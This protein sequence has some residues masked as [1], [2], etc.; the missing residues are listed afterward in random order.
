MRSS[1][2]RPWLSNRHSSTLSALAENSAKLVPR[3]SQLA[4]RREKVPAVR[5]IKLAFRGQ[6][7]RGQRRDGEIELA[8]WPIR[9]LNAADIAD[10]GAA[11]MGG[12][13]IEY[14]T[15][16]AAKRHPDA[17]I[18]INIRREIDDDDAA[19]AG[20]AALAHPCEHVVIGV[21]GN[22]PLKTIR[23]AVELMQC[24]RVAIEAVEVS[25]QSLNAGMPAL[26]EQVPVQRMV[27]SPFAF[28]REFAAHEQE[29]LAGMAEHEAVIGAQVCKALPVVAGHAP[30]DRACAVHHLVMRQRQDEVFR[31]GIVQAEQ[32]VAVV[33]F[34]VDGILA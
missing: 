23:L 16:F 19:R 11:I 15:P 22:D 21:F 4:P 28:L 20:V 29:L 3:P 32:D 17:V 7:Y 6:E 31:E 8:R 27:V 34:A 18:V 12:I 14:F 24:G 1:S 26:V 9:R 5:R 25:D 33:I 2:R 30:Q 13:G 10:I